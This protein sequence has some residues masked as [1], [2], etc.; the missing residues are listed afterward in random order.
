MMWTCPSGYNTYGNVK[1]HGVRF[2]RQVSAK[3]SKLTKKQTDMPCKTPSV[4]QLEV[5]RLTDFGLDTA[6]MEFTVQT[7]GLRK[8]KSCPE[9]EGKRGGEREGRLVLTWTLTVL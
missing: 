1:E 9:H 2:N 3:T 6:E 5:E 7:R 4:I 8:Q